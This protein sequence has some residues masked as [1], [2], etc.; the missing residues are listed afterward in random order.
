M[1]GVGDDALGRRVGGGGLHAEPD[2][3]I[4]LEPDRE[5]P[6]GVDP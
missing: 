4:I 6:E 5:E 2:R 3:R 1:T